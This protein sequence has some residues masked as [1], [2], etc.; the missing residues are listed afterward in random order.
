MLPFHC[1]V[2]CPLQGPHL[3]QV[4]SLVTLLSKLWK[5][6][7]EELQQ[8]DGREARGGLVHGLVQ[9]TK[10]CCDII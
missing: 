3:L 2:L 8:D 5:G 10:S 9:V 4:L 1:E 7:V 6:H